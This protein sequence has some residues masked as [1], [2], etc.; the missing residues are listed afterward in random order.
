MVPHL[1]RAQSAYKDMG[2]LI[3]SHTQSHTHTLIHTHTHTHTNILSH[4][5]A[6]MHT[7]VCSFHHTHSHTHIHTLA[8]THTHTYTHEAKSLILG[9]YFDLQHCDVLVITELEK[10]P[11]FVNIDGQKWVAASLTQQDP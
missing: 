4:I 1:V 6:C 9:F 10:Q 11:L 5:H 7:W 3:S 2:M 8:R